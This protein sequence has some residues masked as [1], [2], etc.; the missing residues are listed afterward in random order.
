MH[1]YFR[2]GWPQFLPGE[3]LLLQNAV[4][5]AAHEGLTG[6]LDEQAPGTSVADLLSDM[7]G[8][9]GS[10]WGSLERELEE[11]PEDLEQAH[12]IASGSE[13]LD[14]YG[15]TLGLGSVRT[16]SDLLRLMQAVGLIE[17]LDEDGEV[18]WRPAEHVPLPEER[19]PLTADEKALADR[20]RW[21]DLHYASGQQ[22]IRF[23]VDENVDGVSTSLEA[24]AS[25]L[26]MDPEDV[27]QGI[28]VL[29]GEGDFSASVDIERVT[30]QASFDL[31][32][33]WNLFNET[34]LSYRLTM[35]DDD[36]A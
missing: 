5:L 2:A 29:L 18:R 25:E 17:R 8:Y 13:Q 4:E 7:G 15:R 24:L 35:P 23:F 6:E 3:A 10:A 31:K 27:R 21:Q 20:R 34:R 33:D 11:H 26:D 16:I 14:R 22:I 32:V 28:L 19:L 9:D 30:S 12:L 36:D 1:D